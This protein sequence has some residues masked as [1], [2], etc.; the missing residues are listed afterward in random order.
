MEERLRAGSKY[1]ELWI[2]FGKNWLV[3]NGPNIGKPGDRGRGRRV[4]IGAPTYDGV[5]QS[6]PPG[7]IFRAG[8][9]LDNGWNGVGVKKAGVGHVSPR[10]FRRRFVVRYV[11]PS[12]WFCGATELGKIAPGRV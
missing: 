7:S 1:L 9:Y 12:F 2:F 8:C 5:Y 6:H 10:A 4:T 11:S 3:K